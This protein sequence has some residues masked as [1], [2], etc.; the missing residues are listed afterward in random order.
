MQPKIFLASLFVGIAAAMPQDFVFP[1]DEGDGCD[2]GM[3]IDGPQGP[4]CIG[5][6]N[7]NYGPPKA[8]DTCTG[9]VCLRFPGCDELVKG[10]DGCDVCPPGC[11]VGNKNQAAP[12]A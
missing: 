8:K 10:P 4:A 12:Q 11:E 1:D 9:P 5:A 2:Q 6:H 3:A 7:E